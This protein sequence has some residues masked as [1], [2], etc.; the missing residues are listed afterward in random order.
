[1]LDSLIGWRQ[2]R[3]DGGPSYCLKTDFAECESPLYNE[4][5]R[6]VY[7]WCV[8]TSATVGYIVVKK[9]WTR[10]LMGTQSRRRALA[11]GL[12]DVEEFASS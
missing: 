7:P 1:M 6:S 3:C 12:A 8:K 10:G 9:L 11:A 5:E 2:K 4:T